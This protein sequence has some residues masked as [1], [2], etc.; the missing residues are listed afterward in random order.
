MAEALLQ[1]KLG[2]EG[3]DGEFR[4]ASAGVWT[5]NGRAATRNATLTMAELGLDIRQHRTRIVDEWI[6]EGAA[7]I[8]TMTQHHAEALKAEFPEHASRIFLL[9]EMIDCDYDVEDPVGGTMLDYE[10]TAQEIEAMLEEGLPRI[11]ELAEKA[12]QMANQPPSYPI[13]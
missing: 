1:R 9:S 5:V 11:L 2:R 12:G 7:L 4:A 13:T 6:M 10:E 8:L 3:R